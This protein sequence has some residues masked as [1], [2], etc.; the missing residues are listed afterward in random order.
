M[1]RT[2][3]RV[4]ID[5]NWPI[6]QIWKGFLNPYHSQK[7]KSCDG[8]GYNPATKQLSDDWYGFDKAEWIYITP[9]HRY[10]NLAWQYHLTEIEIKALIEHDRLWDFTRIPIT[11]EQIQI[12][13]EKVARGENNWLPFNNGRIP[14]PEEVN[15]WNLKGFG[16]DAINQSICVKARAK[17]LGVQG[18]CEYCNGE[19]ELQQSPKIKKLNEEWQSFEPPVGDGYQL[20]NTTTEG[21]PMSPVFD[22]LEKLCEYLENN[23]ISIFGSD[24]ASKESWFEMLSD[25]FVYSKKGNIIFI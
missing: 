14:T 8:S 7:C 21:H 22:S 17:H 10:N 2:L 3:K 1:G 19:G 15:K 16:H 23:K 4:P 11:E 5:F 24:T 9:E 18:L 6:G 20:W 13:K 12:V 25:D